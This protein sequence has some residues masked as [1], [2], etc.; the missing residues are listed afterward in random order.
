LCEKKIPV[1]ENILPHLPLKVKWLIPNVL[2][3]KKLFSQEWEE[4]DYLCLQRYI[5]YQMYLSYKFTVHI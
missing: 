4:S 1:P 3:R 2:K 5:V